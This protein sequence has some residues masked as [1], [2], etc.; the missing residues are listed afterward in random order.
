MQPG[1]AKVICQLMML[2]QCNAP[3]EVWLDLFQQCAELRLRSTGL[4]HVQASKPMREELV[5][6][7]SFTG[8]HFGPCDD[9]QL[10]YR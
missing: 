6:N 1:N 4:T 2:V 3:A 8:H 7:S 9:D 10:H 5:D